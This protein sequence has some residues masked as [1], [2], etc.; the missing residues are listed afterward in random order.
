MGKQ[1]GKS[2][3]LAG[4]PLYHLDCEEDGGIEVYGAAS[5][6]DQAAIIYKHAETIIKANTYLLDKFKYVPSTRRIVHKRT[7]SFYRIVSGDG[8]AQD[9]VAPNICLIDELHRWKTEKQR[10]LYQVLKKGMISRDK[11]GV[12]SKGR[13]LMAQITTAGTQ[14]D[15]PLCYE[16]HQFA[17]QVMR[18]A[19]SPPPKHFYARIWAADLE[20]H[21]KE[22]DYWMSREARV[23]ANP[24]HEDNGGFMLDSNI[25]IEMEAARAK[26]SELNDYLRLNLN[27]WVTAERRALDMHKWAA[28]AKPL[29]EPLRGRKCWGGLDLSTSIDLTAYVLLFPD[30]DGTFDV[31]PYFWIPEQKMREKVAKDRVPYDVWQ[32]NGFLNVTEG[33]EINYAK[34]RETIEF[35]AEYYELQELCYDPHQAA[36][37]V[38][39]L[40]EKRIECVPINQGFPVQSAPT[41][42]LIELVTTERIRHAG[43]PVLWFNADCLDVK[44]NGADLIKPVKPERGVSRKRIDGMQAL[45][46]AL[47]RQMLDIPRRSVYED[48]LTAVM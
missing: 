16:E 34:V 4:I 15:S 6:K 26:P 38:Q 37:T 35:T 18:G 47:C 7:L 29:R 40:Q 20:R 30:S 41:K 23:A 17:E 2:Y 24:S 32:R 22:P 9:G 44:G 5:V 39:K 19:I 11:K 12:L 28:C 42:R 21:Q 8:D 14:Y 31:L 36:E 3:L 46:N 45:I 33:D 1:N 25:V 10:A 43:H 13:H 48:P 27:L